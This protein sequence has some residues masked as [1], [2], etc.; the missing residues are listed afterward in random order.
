MNILNSAQ[1]K[2][3]YDAM[4]ALN[5]VA[6]TIN[7]EFKIGADRSIKVWEAD[8]AV[9]FVKYINKETFTVISEEKYSNQGDF[10]FAYNLEGV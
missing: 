4:T 10:I 5:N 6:G 7:V 3:I 1:A 9:V 2:A 8:N